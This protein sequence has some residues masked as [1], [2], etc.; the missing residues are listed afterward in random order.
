M[1]RRKGPMAC[2]SQSDNPSLTSM[3]P[4]LSL[5]TQVGTRELYRRVGIAT[6]LRRVQGISREG[7]QEVVVTTEAR[8]KPKEGVIVS[9]KE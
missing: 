1:T 6:L 9:D 2:I 7:S 8:T 3:Q 5:D 4:R